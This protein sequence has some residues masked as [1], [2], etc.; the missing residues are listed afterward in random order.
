MRDGRGCFAPG[1]RLVVPEVRLGAASV[2]RIDGTI[3]SRTP[4]G[5]A[6]TLRRF[7]EPYGGPLATLFDLAFGYH[8]RDYGA[9]LGGVNRG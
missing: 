6:T 4:L 7:R 1:M 2:I 5:F 8:A 9:S 3:A